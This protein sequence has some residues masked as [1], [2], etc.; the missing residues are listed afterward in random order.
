MRRGDIC[1]VDFEP[2]RGTEADKRRPAV[3]VSNDGANRRAEQ[4]G[5]GV[6]AVVPLTSRI[7]RIYTFQVLLPAAATGL[8]RDSKAQAE[9]IRAIDFE[10]LGSRL[11][12][13]PMALMVEIDEALR[14]QLAL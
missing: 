7:D 10:R 3:I 6:L 12:S 5:R 8:T 14:V 9:Q 4:L 11:G 1:L 2:S 13:V